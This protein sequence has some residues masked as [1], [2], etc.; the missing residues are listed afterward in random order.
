M[1]LETVKQSRVLR[2]A[3]LTAFFLP[4]GVFAHGMHVAEPIDFSLPFNLYVLGSVI[5][6]VVSFLLMGIFNGSTTSST[7]SFHVHLLTLRSVRALYTNNLL[8]NLVRA[9]GVASFLLLITSGL[10]GVQNAQENITPIGV[11]VLF[12]VGLTFFTM[13]IG[14]IWSLLHPIASLLYN[15]P[16]LSLGTTFGSPVFSS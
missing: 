4:K 5:A 7:S 2:L 8:R 1:T 14:D 10:F 11:W 12:G 16:S 9:F 13:L 6:V 15:S 3:L